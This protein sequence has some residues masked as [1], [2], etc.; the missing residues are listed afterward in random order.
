MLIIK[1]NGL[2]STDIQSANAFSYTSQQM[3][4]IWETLKFAL[5]NRQSPQQRDRTVLAPFQIK[6]NHSSLSHTTGHHKC[7]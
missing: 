7:T 1:P 3:Y 2:P 4:K 5:Q 6:G